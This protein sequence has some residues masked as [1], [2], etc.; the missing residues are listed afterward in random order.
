[1]T[2][3]VMNGVV[4]VVCIYDGI[5]DGVVDMCV[6]GC[7]TQADGVRSSE[8]RRCSEQREE[9]FVGRQRRVI[10]WEESAF[11][12]KM[13]TLFIFCLDFQFVEKTDTF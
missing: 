1:M 4:V 7:T 12:S 11:L 3:S 6:G 8:A 2:A 9:K 5:A 10:V 13:H